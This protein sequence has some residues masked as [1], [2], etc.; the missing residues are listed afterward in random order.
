[1]QLILML[2]IGVAI[3]VLLF[4]AI[5]MRL[6]YQVPHN[7]KAFFII[8]V[9]WLPLGI[10]TGNYVFSIVG[11]CFLGI[12][13]ANRKKWNEKTNWSDLPPEVRRLKKFMV[14][15]LG[16]LP[17]LGIALYFLVQQGII[18]I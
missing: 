3:L 10:I 5:I 14:I 1:M 2:L 15:F 11:A 18:Q 9:T 4:V 7:Y 13:L 8:G 16:V 12:G 6:K 17:L